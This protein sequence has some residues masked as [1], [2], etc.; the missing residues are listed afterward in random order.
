M[1]LS[2]R[3]LLAFEDNV[4][5]L[6]QHRQLERTIPQHDMAAR[7]LCRIR[8][9]VRNARLGVP[10]MVDHHEEL[11]PN[12]VAEYL[13]H[14]ISSEYQEQFESFCF[15]DDKYLAE[16]ASV[17]QVLSNVLGEPART[18]RECRFRC[19][20]LYR[21]RE[22]PTP[23]TD[24]SAMPAEEPARPSTMQ[25]EPVVS[26]AFPVSPEPV[27]QAPKDRETDSGKTGSQEKKP[28]V[29]TNTVLIGLIVIFGL[30]ILVLLFGLQKTYK[31]LKTI[32]SDP[33]PKIE[34]GPAAPKMPALPVSPVSPMPVVPAPAPAR[35]ES[36]QPAPPAP[37][38]PAPAPVNTELPKPVPPAPV[39]PV[40]APAKPEPPQPAP[41]AP[42][43]PAPVPAKP[44][45]RSEKETF[46]DVTEETARHEPEP[47]SNIPDSLPPSDP[48]QDT[49][50]F[51]AADPFLQTVSESV[52]EG[53][54]DFAP[55]PFA[56]IPAEQ[57]DS[58][59][60]EEKAPDVDR[61]AQPRKDKDRGSHSEI[62]VVAAM[63][64][65]E[66][67]H[68]APP[69]P[70]QNGNESET[71]NPANPLRNADASS[72]GSP[73]TAFPEPAQDSKRLLNERERPEKQLRQ[74]DPFA[75]P[76][77]KAEP[78]F[79]PEPKPTER[80]TP[81]PA[82]PGMEKGVPAFTQPPSE[83]FEAMQKPVFRKQPEVSFH[84]TP[85][86]KPRIDFVAQAGSSPNTVGPGAESFSDKKTDPPVETKKQEKVFKAHS[87]GK[88]LSTKD[89]CV[90]FSAPS[91][92]A[93]WR[94]ESGSIDLQAEQY[95]LTA[96]PFRAELELGGTIVVEMIGDSKLC[97][98]PTEKDGMPGIFLDYGRILVR[99]KYTEEET[100][101]EKRS[102]RSLE[103]QTEKSKGTLTFNG[104]QSLVFIDTF[105]EI[106]E[107]TPEE[108][109]SRAPKTNPILGLLP[110]PSEP[111]TW[112]IEGGTG[113]LTTTHETSVL[114]AEGRH[115]QGRIRNHP[116]WLR[117]V[118]LPPD[119]REIEATC[120]RLFKEMDGNC[121][122]ALFAL[123]REPS[124]PARAFGFRLWGDLG[125]FD[126]PLSML[127]QPEDKEDPIRAVLASYFRE[128][129]K[130]DGETVQRLADAIE[131]VRR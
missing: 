73:L 97:V 91:A 123:I 128:V 37:V 42:V 103:I 10:G 88:V 18:N 107:G 61:P 129:M 96:A 40:P 23:E 98:L 94:M 38:A 46:S 4:F 59:Q 92:N 29:S 93:P 122:S 119:C 41:P 68:L 115:D 78:K 121:E 84:E 19:Y 86:R 124:L 108:D 83:L 71:I 75:E 77:L 43:V 55:S 70:F 105:A 62:A 48:P 57:T 25:A 113:P 52:P 14:Q 79:S 50:T 60:H 24:Q 111:I 5:D 114:L 101:S 16:V 17:H 1:R 47:E 74:A 39:A 82:P 30:T 80:K 89:P 11:D 20:D 28:I 81:A 26:M 9:V 130:R 53:L 104:P 36:P 117:R 120:R 76:E 109:A 63:V 72:S 85:V 125:R 32:N 66:K 54:K 45:S 99:A 58:L 33:A 102:P 100:K 6:E 12:I 67:K 49:E 27:T 90:L 7:A 13:D 69:H 118:S 127:S 31:K 110:D 112:H 2:L 3:T 35:P 51:L 34:S 116:N 65:L 87:L 56:P 21:H 44:L 15:S 131:S 95:L 126:I 64:P 106:V 22:M 8:D